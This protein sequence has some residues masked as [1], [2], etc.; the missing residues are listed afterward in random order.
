MS[1]K[2]GV[3]AETGNKKYAKREIPKTTKVVSVKI[4]NNSPQT[5]VIGENARF[6][7]G[8]SE[9]RLLDPAS[10]HH[11]LKQGVPIYLLYLLLSFITYDTDSGQQNGNYVTS[12]SNSIPIGLIIGP[13]ISIGNMAG[14]GGANQHFLRELTH[15]N[16][17]NKSIAPG[18]TV[19]GLI[20]IND[21]G[22]NPIKLVLDK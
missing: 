5:I 1:Y 8:N 19:Y 16:M 12:Q 10:V 17:I 11:Q 14:A 2:H 3:L 9:V 18:Q 21:M 4:T 20:G 22:Y 15:F 6:Y 7:S 13:G